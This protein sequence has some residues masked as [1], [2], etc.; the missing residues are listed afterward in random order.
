MQRIKA[1]ETK[2]D[3]QARITKSGQLAFAKGGAKPEGSGRKPGQLNRVTIV[4]KDCILQAANK[5]GSDGKGK[6][7]ATGYLAW[8]AR[9]HPELYVKLL[10][11]LLPY[12]LAGANGTGPVKMEYNGTL[13]IVQRM[14]ERGLPIPASLLA[15]P[16]RSRKLAGD[17]VIDGDFEEVET[18]V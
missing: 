18:D 14:K 5:C 17:D 2:A 7:E 12:S 6:D 4:L 16:K 3:K 9:A 15:P 13:E 8:L 1:P 11:K 10:E